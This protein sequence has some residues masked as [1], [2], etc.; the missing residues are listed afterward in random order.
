MSNSLPTGKNMWIRA[1]YGFSPE[2][3]GYVGWSRQE[4][5]ARALREL[6]DGDLMLIY[7]ASTSHTKKALHAHVLGFVEIEARAIFDY[8]K[9]S[10]VELSSKKQ[11]GHGEKWTF[12]LPIRRA[13]RADEKLL[14]QRIAPHTYDKDKAQGIGVWGRALL[15]EEIDIAL[16]IK[17]TEVNVFGEP[18]IVEG[19]LINEA[20]GKVFVPSKA[21]IG[22]TGTRTSNYE[23]G[24]TYLYLATYT[25]DTASF[26]DGS[27]LI[28]KQSHA[29]KIGV[30][31]NV[32]KRIDQLNFGIPPAASGRWKLELQAPYSNRE[33]AENAEQI[34]KDKA[35][36]LLKSLGKEY[37]AGDIMTAYSIFS[38][39]PD[40]SR[41][42]SK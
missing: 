29:I 7:G 40:V 8:Q 39:L 34:F 1:F 11:N 4:G 36:V 10:A 13:W 30:S 2:E 5:Q 19:G 37:F 14:I 27:V 12:A 16:K 42:G 31:N 6:Q 38:R 20:I 33:Q 32:N 35:E 25:G 22:S 17:V 28:D 24:Q 21:F 41:F 9:A 23:D 26:V 3:A 15:P 18:P